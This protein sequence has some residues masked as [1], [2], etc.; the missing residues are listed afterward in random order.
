MATRPRP[1]TRTTST[2]KKRTSRPKSSTQ[3]S[4]QSSFLGYLRLPRLRTTPSAVDRRLRR[5]SWW[6]RSAT[7]SRRTARSSRCVPVFLSARMVTDVS[8]HIEPYP[9]VR[10]P[11][12]P[13][14]CSVPVPHPP[15]PILPLAPFARLRPDNLH[16][17][18]E[19]PAP[20]AQAH[21]HLLALEAVHARVACPGRARD[22]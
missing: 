22:V 16:S 15:L 12:T 19:L 20:P 17:A 4:H 9:L 8:C 14:H 3:S 10:L 13:R 2:K 6:T 1:R 11:S 18:P 21:P 7:A 5:L